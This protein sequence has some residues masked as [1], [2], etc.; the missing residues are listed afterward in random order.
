M[1][2]Q[3][4]K[5]LVLGSHE[6]KP[7]LAIVETSNKITLISLLEQGFKLVMGERGAVVVTAQGYYQLDLNS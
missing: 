3:K 2:L 1:M 7:A 4:K 6:G 5:A